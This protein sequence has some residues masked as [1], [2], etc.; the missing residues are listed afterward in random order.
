MSSCIIQVANKSQG[1]VTVALSTNTALRWLGNSLSVPTPE[2]LQSF[3][4]KGE[5]RVLP[6]EKSVVNEVSVWKSFTYTVGCTGAECYSI[7]VMREED[8]WVAVCP[9]PLHCTWIVE[10]NKIYREDDPSKCQVFGFVSDKSSYTIKVANQ[11]K[12]A[13]TVVVHEGLLPQVLTAG[14]LGVL[15]HVRDSYFNTGL[16]VDPG[17]TKTIQKV[18]PKNLSSYTSLSKVAG[19]VKVPTYCIKVERDKQ[20]AQCNTPMHCTWIVGSHGMWQENKPE[21]VCPFQ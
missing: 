4:T 20:I 10:E 11:T 5:L 1:P 13:V 19:M 3:F 8:E 9:S 2:V 6:G 18:N 21:E 7:K 17:K 14:P 12:E 15:S 16:L